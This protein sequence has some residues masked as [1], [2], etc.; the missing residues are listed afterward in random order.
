M[1]AV[2]ETRQHDIQAVQFNTQQV[3]LIKRTICK[4]ASDD[5][6][7][8]FMHVCKRTKLD[9]FARQIYAVKRWDSREKREVMAIQTSIDGFRLI[10]ERNG[11]Y[12]GQLGPFWSDGKLYPLYDSEGRLIGEDFRWLSAW[13]SATP[14]AAA[15]VGALRRDFK[16][17]C[18]GVATYSS[19]CQTNKDGGPSNLWAKMPEVMLAKCAESLALRKAFPNELSDVYT[20]EE[21]QQAETVSPLALAVEKHAETIVAIKEGIAS[22]QLFKAAEAWSEL[23]NDEKQA[24]WV[25]PSKG[26]PFTTQEREVMKTP[27][28]RQ[29]YTPDQQ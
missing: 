19:Y 21:M 25:A 5:E 1:N 14:P 20:E 18:W 7:Q 9:P 4:G 16:E 11:Q 23:N 10:A 8:L 29:A 13:I 26:G 12:A 27:E 17:P 22:G 15:R 28:F 2:V 24:L 6:L 3:D